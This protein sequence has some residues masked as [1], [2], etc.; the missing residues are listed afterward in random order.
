MK[1][2]LGRYARLIVSA[3][4][5]SAACAL[6]GAVQA[7]EP[8]YPTRPI[9]LVVPYP[10][11]GGTDLTARAVSQQMAVVLGQALVIENKPG[12]TGMIGANAVVTA[13]PDGYT[14]LFG[15][16]SEMAINA[17]LYK[18]MAYDPQRQL[19]PVSLV[20]T[21]PLILVAPA[22]TTESLP[23]L[24]AQAKKQPG[25]ISYGS[26]GAGSPQHLAAELMAARAGVVLLHVPY[27]GSGPLVQASLGG[28]VNIGVSSVPPAVQLIQAGKL[29]ALA[30][31]SSQR[32]DALPRCLSLGLLVRSLA[33]GRD[34]R[35][36]SARRAA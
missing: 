21:F 30:L 10:P 4:T 13:Q 15:A 19:V 23:E 27:K 32:L 5:I 18:N 26:I 34:S 28:Q 14:V 3:C 36:R 16:A 33:R 12:A 6:S 1:L 22:Q 31:T 7:E 29:R 2:H 8:N 20:A 17:S 25:T 11:G 24:L 9:R 35:C